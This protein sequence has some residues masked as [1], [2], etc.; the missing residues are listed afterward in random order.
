MFKTFSDLTKFGI[1]IF[2]ILSGICGYALS[3]ESESGFS[4]RHFLL[5]LF[6]QFLLSSGSLA[7]NQ[8][9]EVEKDRKMP[10][11]E[12]RP[13]VRGKISKNLALILSLGMLAL[14]L[15]F[16]FQVSETCAWVGLAIVA[17]YNGF[18]TYWWKPRWV[19]AAIPGAIP[20]ALPATM[21]YA[22]NDSRIFEI[23][24]IYLFAIMFLWQM[25]HF[26]A[27][28]IKYKDDYAAG[29]V[30]TMPVAIGV[31]RTLWHMGVYTFLYV[32]LALASPL[33]VQVHWAFAVLVLPI[34]FKVLQ[35][36]WRF[37]KS[38]GRERWLAFFLWINV[39][40]LVYQIVPV[41]DKWLFLWTGRT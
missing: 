16:L 6:G 20:G 27:L 34:S 7:L 38:E 2:V 24:S 9:Q 33:F 19:F 5:F 10:R 18:Y 8:V 17:L 13:I 29:G 37:Y 14:G 22:A 25:P 12:K 23:D 1:T 11:T 41:I 4:G 36:F 32:L 31:H 28:A 26:W 3:F 39:S 35:E 15:V 21:G 40:V 30:P